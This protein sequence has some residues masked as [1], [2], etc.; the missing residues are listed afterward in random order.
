MYHLS[1]YANGEQG[2]ES[3]KAYRGWTLLNAVALK[4]C[5]C[6]GTITRIAGAADK[7]KELSIITGIEA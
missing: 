3:G 1:S 5:G 2:R 4:P 6:R 7:E